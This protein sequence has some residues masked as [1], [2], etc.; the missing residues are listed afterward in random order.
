MWFIEFNI[1]LAVVVILFNQLLYKKG[2]IRWNRWVLLFLPFLFFGVSY[3]KTKIVS[4]EGLAT[5]QY[6]TIAI[7]YDQSVITDSTDWLSI[8]YITGVLSM[9]L[10]FLYSLFTVVNKFKNQ[11][12]KASNKKYV[13]HQ[14]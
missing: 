13:I 4:L 6:P 10:F 12:I 11:Q 14:G 7:N 9:L 8:I 5:I 2:D 3:F 1:I